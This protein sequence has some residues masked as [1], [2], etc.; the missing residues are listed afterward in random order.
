MNTLSAPEKTTRTEPTSL[1]STSELIEGSPTSARRER[2]GLGK[3]PAVRPHAHNGLGHHSGRLQWVVAALAAYAFVGGLVTL[4]GWFADLPRLTDWSG[5]GISMF[6]NTAVAASAA[7]LAILLRLSRSSR[8]HAISRGL[9]FSVAAI[10]A[11]TLVEHISGINLGLDTLLVDPLWGQKAA[12]SPGRMGPP[13][14][15]SFS[16]L[17]I[18]LVLSSGKS[19]ARRVVPAL[20][21][22]VLWMSILAVLGYL[23]DA[24]PLFA[25]AKFT[26]I[27][28]PTASVVLALALAVVAGVP[29]LEPIRTLRQKSAGGVLARRALPFT[30][31]LPIGLGWLFILGRRA[32]LFDRGMGTAM[33]TLALITLLCALLWWCVTSVARYEKASLQSETRLQ[34]LLSLM[35][36]A[37]Y[38]CDAEGRITFFNRRAVE[39]WGREP[40]LNGASDRFCACYKVFLLDGTFVP[41]HETPMAHAVREGRSFRNVEAVVERPDGSKFVAAVNVDP[42]RD[43]TGDVCGAVNVFQDITP[44]KRAAEKLEQAVAERTASL[45]QAVAQMEEFSYSVSHDLRAP[46]RGIEGFARILNDD[47]RQMLPAGAQG[48]LDKISR[49]VMHMN[50]LINDV[51]TLTRVTQ[52]DIRLRP[53]RLQALIEEIIEQHAQMQAPHARIVLG[54]MATVLA[55]DVSLRQA[56]SNLLA[57]AVKFVGPDVVP[58]VKLRSERRGEFVRVWVEDNGIG[59]APELHGKLFGMFRRLHSNTS[60]DGTG[61]GLA[62]VRKAVERMGGKVG[63]ESDGKTGSR[64]WIELRG[65]GNGAERDLAGRRQ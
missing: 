2:I 26:G 44:L 38:T 15:V 41:P 47:C 24:N 56:L 4:I 22:I 39:L 12:V 25:T 50:R 46:L 45:Q 9:G 43:D 37:V 60:Y 65:I 21:I 32:A 40:A 31:L 48:L 11:L 30:L 42:L 3:I 13:A 1:G 17:G 52:S 10:G 18:A 58:T 49:N 64:F 23:F 16:L 54:E 62:I 51:L 34:T 28:L 63:V 53:V 55:D 7:G 5:S 57:N 29:D 27:A 20:G 14:S 36:A 8:A 61:I 6:A 19:R 59:I 33:L 35:P